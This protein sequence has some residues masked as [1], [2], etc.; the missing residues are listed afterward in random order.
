[1]P[2]QQP[3]G[4]ID[5]ENLWAKPHPRPTSKKEPAR[6][7]DE[8]EYTDDDIDVDAELEAADHAEDEYSD[9]N[10]PDEELQEEDDELVAEG[11]EEV[12]GED[13]IADYDAEI[14]D[15]VALDAD[16]EL[17]DDAAN[18]NGADDDEH[19]ESAVDYDEFDED[20]AD[21]DE[22]AV[23][24]TKESRKSPMAEKKKTSISDHVRAEIEKRKA[25]GAG[26]RGVEIVAALEKRGI[27]VSPAQVSQ[28]LK[29]AGIAP[30]KKGRP[31]AASSASAGAG[32]RSRAALKAGKLPE[33]RGKVAP[34]RRGDKGRA[35]APAA[36]PVVRAA[37][38]AAARPEAGEFAMSV[39]QLQAAKAFVTT[40]G[41][42][43]EKA[44]QI[45]SATE[46]LARAFSG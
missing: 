36:A 35:P 2:K 29:K 22:V 42:S 5:P 28:L 17:E 25:S 45:L 44:G 8:E 15:E 30:A 32:E 20:A 41:G 23:A 1:M 40:C 6:M 19:V 26:L 24:D 34:T 9:D 11:D 33:G 4:F 46:Q 39:A 21:S 37:P 10:E 13:E 38:K 31:A 3:T 12:D 18:E 16:A 43:F 7:D 14:G 27:T